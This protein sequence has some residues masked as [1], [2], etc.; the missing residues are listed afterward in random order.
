MIIPIYTPD[1]LLQDRL[2]IPSDV[3]GK[4]VSIR[5]SFAKKCLE[6]QNFGDSYWQ[7]FGCVDPSTDICNIGAMNF[8]KRAPDY[9]LVAGG[10]KFVNQSLNSPYSSVGG[11]Y[12]SRQSC[13]AI[14]FSQFAERPVDD[15]SICS[16]NPVYE[17][18]DRYIG[19]LGYKEYLPNTDY[20]YFGGLG[21]ETHSCVPSITFPTSDIQEKPVDETVIVT[22]CTAGGK[23]FSEQPADEKITTSTQMNAVDVMYA[24]GLGFSSYTCQEIK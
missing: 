1:L 7:D 15:T 10:L 8:E 2:T 23:Q 3:D 6:W 11:S 18:Y 22:Y 19:G 20:V 4:Y 9:F 16:N 13:V 21:F 5:Y 24:G 17:N 14:D 12:F